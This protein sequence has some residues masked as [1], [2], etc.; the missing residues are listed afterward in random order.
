M[1]WGEPFNK[2]VTCLHDNF[3]THN[4]DWMLCIISVKLCINVI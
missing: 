2:K 1:E 4:I 3:I